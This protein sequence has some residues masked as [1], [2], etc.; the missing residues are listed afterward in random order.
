MRSRAA[1]GGAKPEDA[2]RIE[3]RGVGGGEIFRHE[4]DR[5]VRQI[6]FALLRAGEQAQN[7]LPDIVQISG[8]AGEA[9]VRHLLHLRDALVDHFLP[10]PGRAVFGLDQ[11]VNFAEQ[12][13]IGQERLVGAEDGGFVPA[14]TR[15]HGVVDLDE[16]FAAD[17]ERVFQ[18]L[19]FGLNR[20]GFVFDDEAA[21]LEVMKT[22]DRDPGR[23]AHTADPMSVGNRRP[24]HF[25]DD[26][27]RFFFVAE[28]ALDRF[29][30]CGE[31]GVGI[32]TV[33]EN[34]QRRTGRGAELEKRGHGFAIRQLAIRPN[35]NLRFE[36]I[37][38]IDEKGRRPRV[39][40]GRARDHHFD[41]LRASQLL[42]R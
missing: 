9:F 7:A 23:S 8:A 30:E 38:D 22:P 36:L 27:F 41:T 39:Q 1:R 2:F 42:G 34:L 6:H 14:A 21:R 20:F 3:P 31:G 19:F 10:R 17:L 11:L 40:P 29:L 32:G 28:A 12:V 35:E 13:D 24:N 25:V 15:F 37:C 16:L 4:N 5:L 33:G 18:F 26:R